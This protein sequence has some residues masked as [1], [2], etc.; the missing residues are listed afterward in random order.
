MIHHREMRINIRPFKHSVL[1]EVI[2]SIDMDTSPSL[3]NRLLKA[4]Q[5]DKN[6]IIDLSEVTYM[7]SSGVATLVEGLSWSKKIHRD[8]VLVGLGVNLYNTLTL[9]KLNHIFNIRSSTALAGLETM[10]NTI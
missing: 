10:D 5:S 9:S 2:G 4:Y 6:L 7:D 8:F 1:I 3:R